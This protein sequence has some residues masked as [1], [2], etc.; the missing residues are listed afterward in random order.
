MMSG[1]TGPFAQQLGID[2]RVVSTSGEV[3]QAQVCDGSGRSTCHDPMRAGTLVHNANWDG[4]TCSMGFH[5]QLR[6]NT[7]QKGFALSG[8]CSYPLGS[9]QWYMSS[10]A[11]PSGN[12]WIGVVQRNLYKD[13]GQ[14]FMVVA[15]PANQASRQIYDTTRAV[16]GSGNP[17]Q[18]ETIYISPG[19]TDEANNSG[20]DSGTVSASTYSY[21]SGDGY[22]IHA[23]DADNFSTRDGDSGSPIYRASGGA[24]AVG[25]HCTASGKFARMQAAL[26]DAGWSIH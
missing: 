21:V 17:V 24:V 23:A 13:L 1:I 7:A 16:A 5:V 9:P 3:N 2:M 22:I 11:G 20:I 14:D 25:I 12:G 15:M 6:S 26:D 19:A 4:V 8:H 10:W 18:G